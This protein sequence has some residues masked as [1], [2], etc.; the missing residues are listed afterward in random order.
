MQEHR[1]YVLI[2]LSTWPG[3]KSS[4]YEIQMPG[5]ELAFCSIYEPHVW[6]GREKFQVCFKADFVDPNYRPGPFDVVPASKRG[7]YTCSSRFR[8]EIAVDEDAMEEFM[9][10]YNQKNALNKSDGWVFEPFYVK[11]GVVT[12]SY[13]FGDVEGTGLGLRYIKVGLLR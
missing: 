2:H 13:R 8:P 7:W 1:N 5:E 4:T 11:L 12:Y 9:Q 10:R 6:Q 3:E